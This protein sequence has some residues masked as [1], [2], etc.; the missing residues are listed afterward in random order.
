MTP[1]DQQGELNRLEAEYQS[2]LEIAA[3]I[4]VI[5]EAVAASGRVRQ[6]PASW[7]SADIRYAKDAAKGKLLL[8]GSLLDAARVALEKGVNANLILPQ[9]RRDLARLHGFL[10]CLVVFGKQKAAIANRAKK[11]TTRKWQ[12]D[13]AALYRSRN[14]HRKTHT[15]AAALISLV[16][17][18]NPKTV[19]TF[20][21]KEFPKRKRQAAE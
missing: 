1:S 14:L 8:A 9:A 7:F 12:D 17:H 16:V 4:G 3:D 19:A 18:I 15:Q 21:S 6:A 2:L 20:L 5:T 11:A 10:E 13:A